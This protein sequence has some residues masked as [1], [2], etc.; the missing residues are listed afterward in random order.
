MNMYFG[1]DYYPEHWPEKRWEKDAEMMHALGID[2]VRMAEFSWKKMEPSLGKF[3]F[4]WLDRAIELFGKY[5]IKTILGTP[6]AAPPAW[7]IRETPEILP[8]DANGI[9]REFGGRHHDC[10]SNPIYRQHIER[11]VTKMA[12]HFSDNPNVVGWQIDNELGNSHKDFCYCPSCNSKFRQWLKKR[13]QT[14]DRLNQAWGTEFWSQG[15]TDFDE[16]NS[17]KITVAG[18]NPSQ[19]LDWMRFCSDLVVEFAQ[20]QRDIIH[21]YCK[22]Q[23]ITHNC[24]GY[25]DKVNYFDLGKMLDFVSHDQ[26]P[27]LFSV[28]GGERKENLAGA[29]DLMRSVK[30]KNFWIMEQQAGITGW[31]IMGKA[32]RPGQLQLWTAQSIAHGADAIVYFRWRTCTVGTEQYWHGLLSHNGEKT[33]YYEEIERT[34]QNLKPVLQKIQGSLPMAETA[35]LFS[36]DQDFAFQIQPH[37]PELD[38]IKQIKQ[39]YKGL[40]SRNVPVEFVC[41]NDSFEPY[42]LIIAPLQYVMTPQMEDKFFAYV[43]NGGHL[44]LTMRTGVKDESNRCMCDE[45]LP[46]RLKDLVGVTVLEYDCLRDA[47]VEVLWNATGETGK[48]Y[49]WADIVTPVSAESLAVYNQEYYKGSTVVSVNQYG[50][51]KSYYVGTEP[52]EKLM[53]LIMDTILSDSGVEGIAPSVDGVEIVRRRCSD[54]DCIFVLNHNEQPASFRLPKGWGTQ[55]EAEIHELLPYGVEVYYVNHEIRE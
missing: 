13:Y 36:Y 7:I 50:K 43:K 51:G 22:N 46:G 9:R 39:Y 53:D 33:R 16:I 54:Y 30:H 18:K 47:P 14:I 48:G 28:E 25:W 21:T 5:D 2:V 35:I 4:A 3:D 27:G 41:E 42:K 34:I 26:Y 8:V 20:F 45:A 17:P 31:T 23:F 38:Y 6:T 37:H 49:K 32:P 44:V 55:E 12:R 40:Y 19:V 15:Y 52:D 29:L 1:V 10:Q 24:M 11:F